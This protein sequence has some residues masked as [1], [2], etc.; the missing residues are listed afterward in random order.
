MI[1][2][3]DENFNKKNFFSGRPII[4]QNE[5]PWKKE[6]GKCKIPKN[7]LKYILIEIRRKLIIEKIQEV[8]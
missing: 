3:T 2:Q 7:V 6:H 8:L 4:C 5:N 1:Y